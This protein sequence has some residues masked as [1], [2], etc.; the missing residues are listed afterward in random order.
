MEPIYSTP[1]RNNN[2]ESVNNTSAY[3]ERATSDLEK[4][5]ANVVEYEKE[6]PGERYGYAGL[7]GILQRMREVGIN[8]IFFVGRDYHGKY[9]DDYCYFTYWD[10]EKKEFTYDEWGTWAAFPSYDLYEMPIDFSAG[11]ETG[12]IDKEAY[13]ECMKSRHMSILEGIKFDKNVA[14][15]YNLR[16][17]VER[18][19]KWKGEGFLF[20]VT[21]SSYRFATPMYRNHSDDFGISTT[22][23]A[24]IWD[25][26]TN[27]LNRAN[28][29][30]IEFMDEEKIMNEYKVW[31]E[32]IIKKSTINDIH[33]N[34]QYNLGSFI[35]DIDYSFDKFLSNVWMMNHAIDA[36]MENPYDPEEEERKK[37]A[38][39][40]RA[41][42]MPS[43]IEWVKNNTDK[44]DEE[45]MEL[46]LHIFNKKYN[47]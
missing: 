38:S 18:G 23:T 32:N 29:N 1:A 35:L 33:S 19:R 37:K 46:A 7:P 22:Q 6:H 44:K 25:P 20:K 15:D 2:M 39:E 40:F 28:F 4:L 30:F 16:V 24:V 31:A 47:S 13:L 34:G 17:K 36:A 26:I 5:F 3:I 9:E 45:I 8:K 14:K 21:S 42:K 27:I 43:I 10:E 11:W 41:S 12:M